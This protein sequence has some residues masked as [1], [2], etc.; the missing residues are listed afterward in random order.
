MSLIKKVSLQSIGDGRGDL[1]AIE[2]KKT[3]PFAI[4]RVYYLTQLNGHA[5]G[6]HAHKKLKQLVVCLHGSCKFVLDDGKC[7]EEIVLDRPDTALFVGNMIWREMSDF[8]DDCVLMVLADARYDE[9]DYIR[10]YE[11]FIALSQQS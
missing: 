7:R 5:R 10:D 9:A 4:A 3:V 11:H 6:F 1:I 2:G 8:K